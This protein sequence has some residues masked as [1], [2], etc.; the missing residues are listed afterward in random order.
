M[1]LCL[2]DILKIVTYDEITL[3]T[4]NS[5]IFYYKMLLLLLLL[6]RVAFCYVKIFK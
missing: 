4:N 5:Y 2:T 1:W 3:C 6:I